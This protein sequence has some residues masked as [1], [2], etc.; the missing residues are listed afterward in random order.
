MCR[1]AGSRVSARGVALA[2]P[3]GYHSFGVEPARHG[4]CRM[5][6]RGLIAILVALVLAVNPLA[7]PAAEKQIT[8]IKQLA[9]RWQGWVNSQLSGSG[10]VLMTIKEDGSYQSSTE[11]AGG[12]LTVG[13]YY[14][15]GG[16]VKYRSSR[17]QGSVVIS[18]EKGKTIMT[19]TPEGTYNPVSGPA[20][21]ERM[22]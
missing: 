13:Q 5:I 19:I 8:D 17:T 20:T 10:R 12:T 15:E 9:G 18:E 7:A 11:Q 1:A 4:V 3:L 2:A 16:K 22:K 14:L 21:F 6:S